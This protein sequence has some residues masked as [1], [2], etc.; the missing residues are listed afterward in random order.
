MY[1][2]RSRTTNNND[3]SAK[4]IK[5]VTADTAI[6]NDTR[7]NYYL[8]HHQFR[9]CPQ[10]MSFA[11]NTA[12]SSDAIRNINYFQLDNTTKSGDIERMKAQEFIQLSESTY[13]GGKGGSGTYQTIIN[14]LPQHLTYVSGF[15]GLDA[16]L[17]K[18]QPAR[19]NIGIEINPDIVAIWN[20]AH[21]PTT[22]LAPSQLTV[23]Q[24][25]FFSI[26]LPCFY[27][28]STLLYL[29][30]P[31]TLQQRKSSNRYPFEITL[32]QHRQL[33]ERI[34]QLPC[35]VALSCYDSPL[36][37]QYLGEWRKIN[38]ESV[39][40]GGTMAT[41]TLYM[42][43]PAVAPNQ[44]HDTRFLGANYRTREVTRK[45]LDT[46]HRKIDRLDNNERALLF[47]ELRKHH[48]LQFN[49]TKEATITNGGT[50]WN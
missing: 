17:R 40:R 13:F 9:R 34:L 50:R 15:M 26:D 14:Q 22:Q 20:N 43:Y 33:L 16:I 19:F 36:Y 7:L 23:L 37:K 45:R 11:A 10:V 6:S 49:D 31:Y 5:E 35:M 2:F 47:T 4:P 29:D 21:F 44:L 1:K 42:N 39:T 41:E 46:I 38:F 30:P 28:P 18:K 24:S 48:P 27:E 32:E 3:A 25:S 8:K 12:I